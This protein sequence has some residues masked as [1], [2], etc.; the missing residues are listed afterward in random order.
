MQKRIAALGEYIVRGRYE[1]DVE[2]DSRQQ[3][4]EFREQQFRKLYG[5]YV[6]GLNPANA[7]RLRNFVRDADGDI[8]MEEDGPPA[9]APAM[10]AA[11]LGNN[12]EESNPYPSA[13]PRYLT[14]Y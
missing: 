10:T 6:D 8:R 14:F 12:T 4:M 13:P 11:I 3:L 9:A 7:G 5:V 1:L 2:T